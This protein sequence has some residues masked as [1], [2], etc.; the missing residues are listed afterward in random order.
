MSKT[1]GNP[2]LMERSK[3]LIG[4]K[5]DCSLK[6]MRQDDQGPKV[7]LVWA[8]F[9]A[10]NL[11]ELKKSLRTNKRIGKGWDFVSGNV[12]GTQ[13]FWVDILGGSVV[14]FDLFFGYTP[15]NQW[16]SLEN[17]PWMNINVLHKMWIFQPAML[18]YHEK[19]FQ[20]PKHIWVITP[21]NEGQRGF[22][23]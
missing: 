21:K 4:P 15:V 2:V 14:M 10:T 20:T 9:I 19:W 5:N 23:W 11:S 7:Q 13:I 17:G 8:I 16:R 1:L 3:I 6:E 22:P 18:V 12:S